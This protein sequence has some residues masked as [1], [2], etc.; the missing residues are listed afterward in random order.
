MRSAETALILVLFG[1]ATFL[2][3]PTRSEIAW[4]RALSSAAL[5]VC[6]AHVYLEGARWQMG[7]AYLLVLALAAVAWTTA[8]LP[9]RFACAVGVSACLLTFAA[10]SLA[11]ALPVFSLPVP[12]GPYKIGT[13]TRYL[14]DASRQEQFGPRPHPR[15]L[16][17]QIWY[18][19]DPGARG[20]LA[21]YR[22]EAITTLRNARFSMVR[23]HAI[24]DAP[25]HR[26]SERHPVLIYSPSWVGIRTENTVLIEN[27]VS[28]GYVVV[29]ID[30]PYGSGLTVFPDGRKIETKLTNLDAFRSE[31][32][33]ASFIDI[34]TDQLR[35]R[36][37]DARFVLETLHHINGDPSEHLL[38]GRLDLERVGI[39]GFSFG[40]GVAAQACRVDR[41]LKAGIN[42]DGVV[43]AESATEGTTSPFLF[44]LSDVQ[45]PANDPDVRT[46][47]QTAFDEH[48][49]ALMKQLVLERRA[50]LLSMPRMLHNNFTDAGFYSL[51]AIGSDLAPLD[52]IATAA[53]LGRYVLTFFDRTLRQ[54]HDPAFER[55]LSQQAGASSHGAR[56]MP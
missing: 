54:V 29:A 10:A 1:C 18:P 22:E 3:A 26:S 39:F 46:R 47:N 17:I 42:I 23:T 52:A 13:Q 30:H 28:Q 38:L 6:I 31:Q 24:V 43:L 5:L 7:P 53:T 41:R 45:P 32:S 55:L 34:A 11:T 44:I 4:F 37:D 51:V 36:V 12:T 27:L 19:A 40:G 35:L 33:L 16:V 20:R 8:T 48:Q 21:P 25:F 15:E 50:Y 56:Q 14:T 2:F 9:A 49:R